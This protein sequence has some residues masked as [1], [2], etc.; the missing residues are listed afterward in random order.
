V[1]YV[2]LLRTQGGNCVQ[3]ARHDGVILVRDTKDRGHGPVHAFTADR[4]RAFVA[5]VRDE[6]FGLGEP[7]RQL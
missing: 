7:G 5:S 4:W 2:Q 3:V 6:T 1:A